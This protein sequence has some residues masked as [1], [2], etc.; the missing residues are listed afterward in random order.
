MGGAA[1]T[2]REEG[3][4]RVWR[5]G[6]GRRKEE[7]GRGLEHRHRPVDAEAAAQLQQHSNADGDGEE[8][9]A[10]EGVTAHSD[11]GSESLAPTA[12]RRHERGQGMGVDWTEKKL[13]CPSRSSHT[14]RSSALHP[15]DLRLLH[16]SPSGV[17]QSHATHPRITH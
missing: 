9:S 8:G 14:A 6:K 15:Y 4:S 12:A 10:V 7:A 5:V 17:S 11:G 13:S 16:S 1:L 2:R 3:G